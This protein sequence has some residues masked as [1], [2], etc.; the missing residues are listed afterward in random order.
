MRTGGF[1]IGS[2]AL[3]SSTLKGLHRIQCGFKMQYSDNMTPNA[4]KM[5]SERSDS[6]ILKIST[7]LILVS[8][9]HDS[10]QILCF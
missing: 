5:Q 6:I 8:T 9:S 1:E 7:P 4:L 2:S 3:T 10:I